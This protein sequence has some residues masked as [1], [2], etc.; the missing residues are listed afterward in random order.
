MRAGLASAHASSSATSAVVTAAGAEAVGDGVERAVQRLRGGGRRREQA[1]LRRVRRDQVLGRH[2]GQAR[3]AR[4]LAREQRRRRPVEHLAVVGRL[5]QRRAP[6][7]QREVGALQLQ[8]HGA[9]AQRRR[10]RSRRADPQRLRVDAR[11]QRLDA[12]EILVEGLLGADALGVAVGDD[13]ARIDRVRLL[14]QRAPRRPEPAR[15]LV[16]IAPRDVADGL[17]AHRRQRARA[18]RPDA[19]QPRDRQRREERGAAVGRHLELAVR[20]GHV[21]RDLGDQLDVRDAGRRGQPD[22]VGDARAQ[23]PGDLG[24]RA[25]Q[26]LR[27]G[28]VQ[29]RLV[30]RQRLDQR[31]DRAEDVEHARADVGVGV[32]ARRHDDRVGRQRASPAPSASR[33]ARRTAAPRTTPPA[34]RRAG[35]APPTMTGRP[36]RAGSSRCSTDA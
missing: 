33:C 9:R 16:R 5:V 15:Q 35:R 13:R 11:R 8:L 21:G 27:R 30:E 24:G 19:P 32:V 26:R 29:E 34:R 28:H 20:L 12:R 2:A 14:P 7:D 10:A 23:P 4:G 36:R 22:L 31:R 17:E 3:R 25:E 1:E 6:G 18:L